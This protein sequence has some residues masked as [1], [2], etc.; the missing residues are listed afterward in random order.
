MASRAYGKAR[1]GASGI[2]G[3]T[4]RGIG[5]YGLNEREEGL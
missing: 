3:L 1:H 4:E 5:Y 2:A